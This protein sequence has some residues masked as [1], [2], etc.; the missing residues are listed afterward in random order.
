MS[1]NP[2]AYGQQFILQA[3]QPQARPMIPQVTS[4]FMMEPPMPMLQSSPLADI[5][6][7][8]DDAPPALSKPGM[9]SED[10]AEKPVGDIESK[11]LSKEGDSLQSVAENNADPSADNIAVQDTTV[12][13]AGPIVLNLKSTTKDDL[14]IMA[15]QDLADLLKAA[16]PELMDAMKKTKENEKSKKGPDKG[17]LEGKVDNSDTLT[18]QEPPAALAPIEPTPISPKMAGFNTLG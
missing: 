1:I 13:I 4:P 11:P 14:T 10:N 15:G 12:D 16:G 5:F 2:L 9:A 18:I 7:R 17:K 6:S 3:P 8:Q